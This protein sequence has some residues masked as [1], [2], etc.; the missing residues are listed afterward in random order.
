MRAQRR[1]GLLQQRVDRRPQ[2]AGVRLDLGLELELVARQHDR[3]AVLADRARDEDPVA[4][5]QRAGGEL[6]AR[7][8]ARPTPV[9]QTYISSAW[10]RSTTLV[11]PVT[12]CT[13]AASAA[14]GD[15]LD[16][17]AQLVG[18][19]ALLEHQRQAQRERARARHR[20]VV[21]G[22]VH[23]Q[24]ADRAAREADRPDHEAVGGQREPR[25]VD[26]HRA[27][28]AELASAS[29]SKAG[30]QQALDQRLAWPCRR[31]RATS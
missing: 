10:P 30:S 28:V 13:P 18:G 4:G 16:L 26:G 3:R 6:G 14:R 17:G 15:R 21:D 23:R 1:P 12:I 7:V 25:A 29:F 27:G 20:E 9:V 19:E 5:P 24:L 31:R 2:R 22:A 8:D 11:S